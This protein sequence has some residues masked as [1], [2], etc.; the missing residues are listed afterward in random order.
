[1]SKNILVVGAGIPGKFGNQFV[2]KARDDGNRVIVFSHKD[3]KTNH[4]DDRYIKYDDTKQ[5]KSKCVELANELPVIDIILFNQNGSGYPSSTNQLFNEPNPVE[6]HHSIDRAVT[7]PHL[8]IASLYNNLINGSKVL[9]MGTAM[10]LQYEREFY[11]EGVGYP[12]AKSYAMH[13]IST[14]ARC[15]TKEIT[16]SCMCPYFLYDKPDLYKQTFDQTYNYILTHD[17]SVNGK[18]MHQF[19]GVENPY[20]PG[21]VQYAKHQ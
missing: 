5:V 6:Y 21:K 16:F 7:I 3:H 13:L 9:Y 1:M 12:G 2:T 11:P 15:R 4:I 19:N 20:V 18:L 8:I 10:A 17:D 14:M